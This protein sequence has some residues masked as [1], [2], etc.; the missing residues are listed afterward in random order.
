MEDKRTKVYGLDRISDLD[1]S[2]KKFQ[3]NTEFDLAQMLKHRFGINFPQENEKP[4]KIVLSFTAKQ[5]KYIKSVPLYKEHE[6]LIDDDKEFRISLYIYPTYDFRMEL[7]SYGETVKVIEPKSLVE[8]MKD[9]YREA[10]KQYS[11]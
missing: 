6:I 5:G 11:K 3:K 7:L 9:V 1:I 4:Q 10:L 2:K 8:Q